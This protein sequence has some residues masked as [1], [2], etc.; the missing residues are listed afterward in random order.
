MTELKTQSVDIQIELICN[1][2]KKQFKTKKSK[3]RHQTQQVCIPRQKRTYCSTCDFT[4]ENKTA[5]SQHLVSK[6]HLSKLV[7]I[8]PHKVDI[9]PSSNNI[10]ALDPYLSKEE[11]VDI[12]NKFS[13]NNISTLTFK[14]KDNTISRIDIARENA[15][16]AAI[17]QKKREEDEAKRKE[18]EAKKYLDGVHYVVEPEN[19][20]DYQSILNA[21]L[22][23][24]PPMTERQTRIIS[25]LIRAQDANESVRKDKLKQIFRLINMDEANYLMSHIRRCNELT[26]AA[27]QFYMGFIDNFIMELIKLLNKGIIMIGD[28]KIEDFITKLSK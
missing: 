9:I 23:T 4:A 27:K 14:H 6:E 20:L 18:E 15:R 17:E 19:K 11:K 10:F 16:I 25:F 5:Y 12:T 26:I 2:C 24:I 1:H 7:N 28:K 13:L 3:T 22:Y 21:E 8:T